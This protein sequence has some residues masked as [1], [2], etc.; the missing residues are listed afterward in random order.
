MPPLSLT[1]P[2]FLL[3][4][5]SSFSLHETR[6]QASCPRSTFFSSPFCYS[7]YL[8]QLFPSETSPLVALLTSMF[9][10]SWLQT[11]AAEISMSKQNAS[12]SFRASD[13]FSPV[14]SDSLAHSFL[15]LTPP[16]RV[17]PIIRTYSKITLAISIFGQ[18]VD[19]R[20]IGSLRDV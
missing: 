6:D 5:F 8:F 18:S 7:L 16:S 10:V 12:T 2:L 13:S 1:A 3:P 20:R 4:H 19:S 14:T 11:P 9:S 17:G 15:H